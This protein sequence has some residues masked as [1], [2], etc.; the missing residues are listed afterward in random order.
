VR[1]ALRNGVIHVL[2]TTAETLAA[3][4]TMSNRLDKSLALLGLPQLE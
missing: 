2:S 4:R 3:V 1:A